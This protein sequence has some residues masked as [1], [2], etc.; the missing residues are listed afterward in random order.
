LTPKEA[1]DL[2]GDIKNVIKEFSNLVSYLF[3]SRIFLDRLQGTAK[4]PKL[5]AQVFGAVGPS[6]RGSGI[7]C[8]DRF[9]YPIE[10]YNDI[11]FNIEIDNDED[12]MA[13]ASVR[14]AEIQSSALILEQLLDKMPVGTVSMPSLGNEHSSLKQEQ[15]D[16]FSFCRIESPSGDLIHAVKLNPKGLIEMLHI[17]PSSLVNWLPFAKSLEGNVFTDFQ[18]AF[19]SFGLSYADSDR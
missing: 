8:D 19:E 4:L 13:R 7:E 9:T 12:T 15:L 11:I 18:F 6:A 16:R 2:F 5:E 14:I 10:P 1:K 3:S 17:R